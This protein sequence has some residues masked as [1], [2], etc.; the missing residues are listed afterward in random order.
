MA[1]RKREPGPIQDGEI[2]LFDGMMRTI[3]GMPLEAKERLTRTFFLL[4]ACA[5]DDRLDMNKLGLLL[6][7]ISDGKLNFQHEASRAE[8]SAEAG[9]G[10]E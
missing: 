10:H 1:K 8:V 2:S 5:E 4:M 9:P 7:R 3:P 6:G